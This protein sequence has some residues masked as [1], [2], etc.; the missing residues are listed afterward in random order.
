MTGPRAPRRRAVEAGSV[1]LWTLGSSRGWA[2][3][4]WPG[5]VEVISTVDKGKLYRFDERGG[6]VFDFLSMP[7]SD[8]PEPS[9]LAMLAFV[10]AAALLGGLAG[11]V[12]AWLQ[13]PIN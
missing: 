8:D 5:A 12:A 9:A 10:T 2:A 1:A 3:A 4:R 6:V 7:K 13:I 11:L